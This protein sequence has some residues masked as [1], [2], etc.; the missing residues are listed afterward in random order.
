MRISCSTSRRTGKGFT[1]VELLVVISIIAILA[2]LLLPVLAG[3]K[4]RAKIQS[5]RT[6]ISTLTGAANQY[7][8]TYSKYP[9]SRQALDCAG[10]NAGS[11]DF[12]FGTTRPDGSLLN[13]TYPTI[14]S[15][16]LAGVPSE[17]QY[18]NNNSEVIAV[19]MDLEKFSDGTPTVNAGHARN[20]QRRSFLSPRQTG[21]STSAG[22]GP[23]GVY[24]D[25]WGNPYIISVDMNSD[26]TTF[27]G[28]YGTLRKEKKGACSSSGN[29]AR[30]PDLVF[31]ARRQSG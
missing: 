15:Y 25:P 4:Q 2:A 22:L 18:Q 7:L 29:P 6:D 16:S 1:L 3:V 10:N 14:A 17:F 26:N 30:R 12:T 5:A 27:D 11:W 24:R 23:D 8:A 13:S 9:G 20:P 19:V 21:S 31:R 28:F